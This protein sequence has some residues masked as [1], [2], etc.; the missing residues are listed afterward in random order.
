M[1]FRTIRQNR[2]L[3]QASS[4]PAD[5]SHFG[6]EEHALSL[7]I[8]QVMTEDEYRS[9]FRFI[10]S[11]PMLTKNIWSPLFLQKQWQYHSLYAGQWQPDIPQSCPVPPLLFIL[12][13]F[14]V[15]QTY[16]QQVIIFTDK[17]A[18]ASSVNSL[19]NLPHFL[20][21]SSFYPLNVPV[22]DFVEQIKL[23]T[24]QI[25]SG[26]HYGY[27]YQ[28]FCLFTCLVENR[29]AHLLYHFLS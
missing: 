13:V 27:P 25:T 28:Q 15:F 21:C 10:T 20:W 12:S 14:A 8:L 18:T 17:F 9:P 24:S 3:R 7:F 6:T 16:N 19:L 11:V 23:I 5:K 22:I 29:P 4:T 2:P 1:N 26:F